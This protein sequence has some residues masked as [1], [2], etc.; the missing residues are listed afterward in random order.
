MEN[1]DE[2]TDFLDRY[3]IPKLKQGQVT[4]INSSIYPTGKR[5]GH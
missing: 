1:I 3:H 2:M 4:Y 5:R